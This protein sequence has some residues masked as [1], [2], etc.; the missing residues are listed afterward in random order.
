MGIT[1]KWLTELTWNLIPPQNKKC[2]LFY[3][4]SKFIFNSD[5]FVNNFVNNL[6]KNIYILELPQNLH[7]NN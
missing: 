4:F 3:F 5:W 1:F 7:L 2:D 6:S